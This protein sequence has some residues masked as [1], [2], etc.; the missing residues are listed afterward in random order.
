MDTG[1]SRLA[2]IPV[3]AAAVMLGLAGPAHA[4]AA[5]ADEIT[6]H[7]ITITLDGDYRYGQ[8]ANGDYWLAPDEPDGRVTIVAMSP[9]FDGQHHGW[10]V[11]PD[12]FGPQGF[13]HRMRGGGFDADLVPDLPYAAS[14]GESIVKTT[15]H[16]MGNSSPR[17]AL[18]SAVVLTIL[19]QAPEHDGTRHFRPP[20]FGHDKPMHHVDELNLALLPSVAAPDTDVPSL[21]DAERR[22][23]RVW[24]DHRRGWTSRYIHPVDNMPHYGSG[25]MR[26]AG[27]VALRLMLDAPIEDRKQAA[28]NYLQ[29]GI[30]L[31]AMYEAGLRWSGAGGH[32]HGRKLPMAM[33]AVLLDH[34]PMKQAVMQR[35][36]P[37]YPDR[38]DADVWQ[39]DSS[40]HYA[41]PARRVLWGQPRGGYWRRLAEGRGPRSSR[42]PEGYIDGGDSPGGG[43]QLCC[44][45]MTWKGT[46][47]ALHL[48]PELR[49]VWDYEPFLDYVDR[50]V[51]FG[52]WTLPD[53]FNR[54]GERDPDAGGRFPDAHNTRADEGGW[55]SSFANA[56]WSLHRVEEAA[57]MPHIEP[58]NATLTGSV[59]VE[60]SSPHLEDATLRYTLDGSL[61]D[62]NAPVYDGPIEVT[63]PTTLRVRAYRDGYL[64]SAA[65]RAVF[66]AED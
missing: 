49:E 26:T 27:D 14:P 50:W 23:E 17:P 25:M 56:M 13:D 20:Y 62:E 66:A 48:M 58:Y 46:A 24:L 42:D 52:A 64:P 45:S 55:D 35:E 40:V 44:T 63:E 12:E 29:W 37:A 11:N 65:N 21:A 1:P 54:D 34:E 9:K 7:G 8:F 6:Q 51:H 22:F 16:D 19:A 5:T 4:Q 39:E 10:Q 28:I 60:L 38:Y 41:V 32:M 59:T 18:Q 43:Y 36:H 57:P 47:L 3:L 33:A 61:P 2:F 15:S 53:P 31:F 30:D